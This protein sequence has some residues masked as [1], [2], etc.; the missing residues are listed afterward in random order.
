M[1]AKQKHRTGTRRSNDIADQLLQPIARAANHMWRTTGTTNVLRLKFIKAWIEHIDAIG[2][3]QARRA[4]D[5]GRPCTPADDAIDTQTLVTLEVTN[6]SRC[7]GAVVPVT[8]Y[9]RVDSRLQNPL[10]NGDCRERIAVVEIRIR[11]IRIHP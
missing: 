10:Q 5:Q 11:H 7:F 6:R 1:E 9:G 2:D 8:A 4:G 3:L